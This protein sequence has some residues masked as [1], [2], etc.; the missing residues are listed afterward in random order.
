[1]PRALKVVCVIGSLGLGGAQKNL[2]T[3]ARWLSED[4]ADVTIVTTKDE[5]HEVYAVPQGIKRVHVSLPWPRWFNLY[6]QWKR[7]HYL[8]RSI[9]GLRPAIV[10]SF[11]ETT[12]VFVLIAL[13]GIRVPVVVSERVDPSSHRVG[14]LWATL[15][16]LV[17]PRAARVVMVARDAVNWANR[18]WP[19]W[20]TLWIPNAVTAARRFHGEDYDVPL[21]VAAGRLVYQKGFDLL[22]RAFAEVATDFPAWR[23]QIFGD[24]PDKEALDALINELG[25]MDRAFLHYEARIG[26]W[27]YQP[28]SIFVLPSRYEGFPNSLAE[29]MAQGFACASFDCPGGPAMLIQDKV[30]GLLVRSNDVA[31][32]AKALQ[33][34]MQDRELRYRLGSAAMRITDTYSSAVIKKMWTEVIGEALMA[35]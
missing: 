15:R 9:C 11:I 10:I 7:L 33:R 30:N 3:L 22:L 28:A 21:I 2:L 17:Y 13:F 23:L 24:G 19:R 16:S 12:N 8:R 32:L 25:L 35:R 6:G 4:G 26:A 18:R 34:L 31:Q 29:A 1:L 14:P 5:L 27:L 20:N